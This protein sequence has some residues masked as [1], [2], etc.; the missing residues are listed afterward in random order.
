MIDEAD[1]FLDTSILVYAALGREDAPELYQIARRIVLEENYATSASVLAEFHETVTTRGDTPMSPELASEWVRTLALKPC[2]AVDDK[3]V[4]EG[5]A[6]AGENSISTRSGITLASARRLGC[7]TLYSE[8]FSPDQ[9]FE[10]VCVV[11]PFN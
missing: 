2:Q 6:L 11:N 5:I 7:K 10:G 8:H 3:L 9:T 1:V 4:R